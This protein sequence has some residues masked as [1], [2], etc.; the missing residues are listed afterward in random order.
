MYMYN[1]MYVGNVCLYVCMSVC[2]YVCMSVCLYVCMSVC[3]HVCMS[4]RLYVCLYVCMYALCAD[5]SGRI[6]SSDSTNLKCGST[7][8]HRSVPRVVQPR[9]LAVLV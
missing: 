7:D 4:V 8:N 3:V 1:Y 2:L 6:A 9:I 5:G